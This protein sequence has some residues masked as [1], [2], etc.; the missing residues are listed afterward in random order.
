MN[1]FYRLLAFFFIVA[2]TF[3]S[4]LIIFFQKD[5]RGF[6][7]A[8]NSVN[9]QSLTIERPTT[10]SLNLAQGPINLDL[11]NNPKFKQLVKSEVD[12]TGIT[13]PDQLKSSTT[14]TS[15]EPVKPESIPEFK[16]GNPNP[17]HAF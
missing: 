16:V 10:T 14:P 1:K 4:V 11:F 17:F 13:L 6:L 15:T 7:S 12:M 5:A 9:N 8:V 2:A 3:F